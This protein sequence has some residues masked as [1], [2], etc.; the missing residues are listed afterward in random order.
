MRMIV[1]VM[2]AA[3]VWMSGVSHASAQKATDDK[4]AYRARRLAE[5]LLYEGPELEQFFVEGQLSLWLPGPWTFDLSHTTSVQV[6]SEV[7]AEFLHLWRHHFYVVGGVLISPQALEQRRGADAATI[8]TPWVGLRYVSDSFCSH[9][10]KGC[11]FAEAGTGLTFEITG[12]DGEDHH[13]PN[14]AWTALFGLGYRQRLGAHA[15][16]GARIDFAYLDD[17]WSSEL[18]WFTPTIFGG[19]AF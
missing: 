17:A 12:D 19:S 11:A 6:G 16:F 1:S 10:G 18:A 8:V 15:H 2:V 9:D 7:G 3:S 13:P 5:A 14:G 4:S